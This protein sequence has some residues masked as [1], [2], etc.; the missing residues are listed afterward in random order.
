MTIERVFG[1]GGGTS[2]GGASEAPNTL[3]SNTHARV[4][5]IL[6]DGQIE[7]VDGAKSIYFDDVPLQAADGAMN[8]RGVAWAMNAGVADQPALPGF[9][10][11]ES[12]T[13]WGTEVKKH[14]PV[15][16]S[17]TNALATAARV[18][19]RIPALCRQASSSSGLGGNSVS[20][21][22]E[23]RAFGGAWVSPFGDVT[24][25]GKCTS[26]YDR[27]YRFT[28]PTNTSGPSHPWD[29]RVTRLTNDS[30]DSNDDGIPD[31][32]QD[33]ADVTNQNQTILQSITEIIE[34]RLSY[35]WTALIGL[36]FDASLFGTSI[37]RRSYR[38]RRIDGLIPS[39][40]DATART[41]AGVWDGTLVPGRNSNPAW[42]LYD[43][44]ES[45]RFGLGRDLDAA[46][47]E[48]VKWDLYEIGRWCD[49]MVPDGFGGEEPRLS[50]NGAITTQREAFDVLQL[51]ASAFRGMTYWSSGMVRAV[52]DMPSD[53]VVLATPANVVDGDF[54][55]VGT[56][57]KARHTVVEVTWTDLDDQGRPAV[58]IVEDAEG[59]ARYG[60]RVKQVAAVGCTSRGMARRV[61]LWTLE[62]ELIEDQTVTYRASFDHAYVSSGHPGVVPGDIVAVQDPRIAGVDMSGRLLAVAST[63]A[64]TLDRPVTIEAGRAYS[65]SIR[66]PDGTL[67]TEALVP[68]APGAH[69]TLSLA[70]ALPALP[71]VG[72]VWVLTS[73]DLAPIPVRV[74]AVAEPEKHVFEIHALKHDPDKWAR[75]DAGVVLTPRVYTKLPLSTTSARNLALVENRAVVDGVARSRLLASWTAP[76]VG[77]ARGYRVRIF[78]PAATVDLGEMAVTSYEIDGV[79]AGDWTVEVTAIS[80]LDGKSAPPVTVTATVVGWV[81]TT[82]PFVS[83]LV[84]VAGASST[85]FTGPD[86][87]LAWATIFPDMT[88]TP[89]LA[90]PFYDHAT[91]EVRT[92]SG[93]VIGSHRAIGDGYTYDLAT[94]MADAAAHGLGPQRALTF[95]VA[96]TDVFGRTSS[97]ALISVTNPPPA[98]PSPTVVASYDGATIS[99]EP[100]ADLDAV[101]ALVWVYD[102]PGADITALAPAADVTGSSVT[103]PLTSGTIHLVRVALYDRFGK[104]GLNASSELQATTTASIDTDHLVPSLAAELASLPATVD[105]IRATMLREQLLRVGDRRRAWS[106]GARVQ[107]TVTEQWTAGVSA[108]ASRVD[109]VEAAITN[110][111]GAAITEEATARATADT[112][113]ADRI[114]IVEAG[115]GEGVAAAIATE[116]IARASADSALAADIS[117]LSATVGE[118]SA[119]GGIKFAVA[120]DQTGALA[121]Y[122]MWLKATSGTFSA[123]AAMTLEVIASGGTNYSQIK[124]KAGRFL[125]MGDDGTSVVPFSVVGGATF[126]DTLKV[127]HTID[128]GLDGGGEIVIWGP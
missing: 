31:D 87:M 92:A 70:A 108:L 55:W 53:P 30:N 67:A 9:S 25:S 16:K 14:V 97:P 68:T 104:T 71:D 114:T 102:T 37:P 3:R 66:M 10:E 81:G 85:V 91:V 111:I 27:S 8:F 11:I 98:A 105:A 61:G 99:W 23:V 32:T 52:A 28:L 58:E 119:S 74:V 40:Y 19:I 103:V 47:L 29:I 80:A 22:I 96:V 73:S 86:V 34:Y 89:T 56:A 43:L 116:A 107:T 65:L 101:G 45:K 41:Y 79:T 106:I 127:R 113:L 93:T 39:N 62:T 120:A 48:A 95:A 112:A 33:Q 17:V 50:F 75:V 122:E 128:I 24:I 44:L 94:H 59:I 88:G 1:S 69:D 121:R 118:A 117:A 18:T 6:G 7:L 126:I 72:A 63:S 15:T 21:R 100:S 64:V 38:V 83:N 4:L 90:N 57:L 84:L 76:A 12:E 109:T 123:T 13:S 36:D 125:V 5:D 42:A 110:D 54:E 78:S 124:F 46:A 49:E 51:V 2:K 60:R 82:Q 26:P 20:F 115:V 35:P 77:A